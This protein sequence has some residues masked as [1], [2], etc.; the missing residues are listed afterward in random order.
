[1]QAAEYWVGDDLSTVRRGLRR[2]W[3]TLLDAL[4]RSGV[5]EVAQ[6]FLDRLVEVVLTQDQEEVQAFTTQAA[7]E[8]LADGIGQQSRLHLNGTMRS[9]HSK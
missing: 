7:Q 5:V 9:K 8:A 1:M 2:A 3:N 4:M 6:A